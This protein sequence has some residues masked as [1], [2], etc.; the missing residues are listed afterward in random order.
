VKHLPREV[1]AKLSGLERY[2]RFNFPARRGYDI[3]EEVGEEAV[4][5]IGVEE[6]PNNLVKFPIYNRVM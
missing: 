3:F 5:K 1:Y 4:R 2:K 6:G